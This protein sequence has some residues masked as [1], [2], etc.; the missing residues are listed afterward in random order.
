MPT[1][2]TIQPI[3]DKVQKEVSEMTSP[4]WTASKVYADGK[5]NALA[6]YNDNEGYIILSPGVSSLPPEALAQY[7]GVEAL[8]SEAAQQRWQQKYANPDRGFWGDFADLAGLVSKA[9]L[10][11]YGGQML[12]GAFG[13]Q[14]GAFDAFDAL[15]GTDAIGGTLGAAGAAEGSGAFDAFDAL[16]GADV[17]GGSSRGG[18]TL[19]Q[20][21]SVQNMIDPATM[22][23]ENAVEGIST[24]AATQSLVNSPWGPGIAPAVEQGALSQLGSTAA[25]STLEQLA[26]GPSLVS[27]A[28]AA[29]PGLAPVLP[30]AGVVAG[31]PFGADPVNLSTIAPATSGGKTAMDSLKALINGTAG[32]DDYLKLLGA[33]GPSVASALW[34]NYMAGKTEDQANKFSSY[35]APYRDKLA[36]SYEP[37]FSMGNEPGYADALNQSAKA[38]LAGL[39]TRGNPAGSPNAWAAT[40]KDLTAKTAFPALQGYRNTLAGAGGLAN[41]NAAG[42]GMT[43]QALGLESQIGPA[44]GDAFGG[45]FGSS[46]QGGLTLADLM[47]LTKQN[48]PFTTLGA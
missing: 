44:I 2:Q 10:M 11:Y 13:A 35:G 34:S 20:L 22:L 18:L 26:Y 47:K 38:T 32:Q 31:L 7:P 33:V 30:A 17:L 14:P 4:G 16:Q 39:S 19:E 1:V 21:A 36:Q 24:D 40:L 25:T 43:G 6:S 9:G 8:T 23:A 48:D 29:I 15:Q 3:R 42:T 12:S 28:A 27:Q 5:G 46:K 41:L 45:L 37:G